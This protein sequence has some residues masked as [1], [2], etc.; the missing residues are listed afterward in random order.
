M[1]VHFLVRRGRV[2]ILVIVIIVIATV[3]DAAVDTTVVFIL[4]ACT[5][6]QIIADS[7]SQ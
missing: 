7:V 6:S 4:I 5:E 1:A 3:I 2:V